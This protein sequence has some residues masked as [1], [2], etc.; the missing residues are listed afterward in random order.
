M[1]VIFDTLQKLNRS[2]AQ[3]E[4]QTTTDRPRRNAYAFKSVLMS[5]VTVALV[6]LVVFALGY[7]LVYGLRQLQ[8]S[9]RMSPAVLAAAQAPATSQTLPVPPEVRHLEAT[10]E[11]TPAQAPLSPGTDVPPPSEDAMATLPGDAAYTPPGQVGDPPA[12]RPDGAVGGAVAVAE[13][14]A[15][16]VADADDRA[17]STSA[18]GWPP[19]GDSR[20]PEYDPAVSPPISAQPSGAFS[21]RISAASPDGMRSTLAP[22]AEYP[23]ALTGEAI[24]GAGDGAP[25]T[26][27]V[28]PETMVSA[29][30]RVSAEGLAYAQSAAADQAPA[31]E[32][33]AFR[34]SPIPRYT[35]L[36]RRLQTAI[37]AGDEQAADR[38]LDEF[39]TAKGQRH[40]YL[41]KIQAYRRIQSGD[42]GA[43]ET[44]LKQVLTLDE[45]DRDAQMNLAVVEANTGRVQAARRRVARLA[46]RFPEDETIAAMG[47]QLN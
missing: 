5:P 21:E 17:A 42:Y 33:S 39:A 23:A 20:V 4:A 22:T 10:T 30:T 27:Q 14:V 36:V 2:A 19:G 41:T 3:T 16:A 37:V 35:R 47:R 18:G 13:A 46:T 38:L 7:G 28:A 29:E 1:S 24:P 40:P 25:F 12:R 31:P 43:A 6:V 15:E 45:T 8:R 32:P 26:Q 11:T 44:L 9:A 34:R